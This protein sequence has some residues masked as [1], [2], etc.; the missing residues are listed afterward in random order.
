MN[1][2]PIDPETQ[3]QGGPRRLSGQAYTLTVSATCPDERDTV[4]R[5]RW[6]VTIQPGLVAPGTFAAV[7]APG[8][9]LTLGKI[10]YE[11]EGGREFVRLESLLPGI[12][13]RRYPLA[14]V[15]IEGTVICVCK[16]G[17]E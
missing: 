3:T 1:I 12:A 14:E 17:E 13:A 11:R 15:T 4:M 2:L 5:Q 10:Y 9:C 8:G 7:R 6:R 16:E